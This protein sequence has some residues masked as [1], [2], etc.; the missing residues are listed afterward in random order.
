MIEDGSIEIAVSHNCFAFLAG[1]LKNVTISEFDSVSVIDT[2]AILSSLYNILWN[3]VGI[4]CIGTQ[5][6]EYEY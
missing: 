1:K 6:P 4:D 2:R 5:K 3:A